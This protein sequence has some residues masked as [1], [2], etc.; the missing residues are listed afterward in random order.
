MDLFRADYAFLN[1]DLAALYKL[2]PPANEFDKVRF[3]A[4]SQR[5]GVLGEAAFLAMTA[6]PGETS[7]TIRGLFVRR[8][9]SVP[10]G[11]RPASRGE[12]QPAADRGG[13]AR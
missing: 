13:K 1:S 10:A 6:K 5:A 12:Q 11:S 2:P 7:P 3:P 4:D 8:T 9:V